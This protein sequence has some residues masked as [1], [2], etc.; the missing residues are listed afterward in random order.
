MGLGILLMSKKI[1]IIKKEPKMIECEN[2][3]NVKMWKIENVKNWKCA[4]MC[5]NEGLEKL[6][7]KVIGL[8]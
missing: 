8:F 7:I 5:K 3:K 6:E 1:E 2:V 4:K